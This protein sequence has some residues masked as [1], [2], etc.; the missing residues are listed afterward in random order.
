MQEI[1]NCQ[2]PEPLS[3][4]KHNPYKY[5]DEYLHIY[6]EYYDDISAITT[7]KSKTDHIKKDHLFKI[8]NSKLSRERIEN[9]N[10]K[11]IKAVMNYEKN[12]NYW[13]V[14]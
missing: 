3:I 2:S 10:M 4:S 5:I 11:S 8:R 13:V 14:Y 9:R 12:I 1:G 6:Q 7:D